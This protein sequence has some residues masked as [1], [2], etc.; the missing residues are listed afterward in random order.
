MPPAASVAF[1]FDGTP[2]EGREG[3]PIAAA[4]LAAGFRVL[5]TMPR[6]GDARGG[7]CMVG[8][9]ADC[10]MVVD[11]TPNVR[12]CLTP[13]AEGLDVRTQHGL[14]ERDVAESLRPGA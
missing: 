14:G 7:Y 9:C 11:G 4:L 1:T 12:A 5:R 3:E 2:I 10:L 6:F 8:R 13:V